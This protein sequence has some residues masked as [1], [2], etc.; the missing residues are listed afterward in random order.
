MEITNFLINLFSLLYTF[1]YK[2]KSFDFGKRTKNKLI[3]K[4]GS[5]TTEHK[6]K[7]SWLVIPK[8]IRAKHQ[9]R[10][11]VHL[12]CTAC[13]L[14]LLSHFNIAKPFNDHISFQKCKLFKFVCLL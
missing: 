3:T 1:F 4:P 8:I 9:I 14:V 10:T 13:R 5:Y 7:V 2:N 11:W 6:N 12:Y